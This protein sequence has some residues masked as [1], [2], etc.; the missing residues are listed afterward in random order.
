[1]PAAADGHWLADGASIF[2]SKTGGAIVVVARSRRCPKSIAGRAG[3][4]RPSAHVGHR[5][6]HSL[7]PRT[8]FKGIASPVSCSIFPRPLYEPLEAMFARRSAAVGQRG[9]QFLVRDELAWR[10]VQPSK[11]DEFEHVEPY[12]STRSPRR[13]RLS[14]S[15]RSAV[16]FGFLFPF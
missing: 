16:H 5:P 6:S 10:R 4:I 7:R 9:H 3:K 15:S 13:H 14:G 12:A 8:A 2:G 1:M 11:Q